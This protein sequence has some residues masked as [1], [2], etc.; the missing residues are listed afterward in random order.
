[1]PRKRQH[2]HTHEPAPEP[3]GGGPSREVAPAAGEPS[4]T[5]LA[6]LRA[7]ALPTAAPEVV[8]F[9][10]QLKALVRLHIDERFGFATAAATSEELVSRLPR[11][12]ELPRCL[13]ACDRVLFGAASP[14]LHELADSRDAA[15][16]FA[17]ATGAEGRS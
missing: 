11:A 12:V 5:A 16:A 7:L 6:K 10:A 15:I 17:L 3:H 2:G 8:P 13:M 4:A 14:A 9:C 1:M